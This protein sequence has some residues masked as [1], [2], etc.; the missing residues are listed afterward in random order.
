MNIFNNSVNQQITLDIEFLKE[1]KKQNFQTISI[2]RIEELVKNKIDYKK[3]LTTVEEQQL[4]SSFKCEIRELFKYKLPYRI[5]EIIKKCVKQ[6]QSLPSYLS[7]NLR[8]SKCEISMQYSS[9]GERKKAL[10]L[11]KQ[12]L[13]EM[14]LLHKDSYKIVE[15]IHWVH[16]TVQ[17]CRCFHIAIILC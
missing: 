3:S 15:P 16:G 11:L 4:Y 9:P 1:A 12:K 14:N 5:Y 7:D 10:G 8:I 2:E 13:I 6:N 17:F